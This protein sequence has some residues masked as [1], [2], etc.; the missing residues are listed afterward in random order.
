MDIA[1]VH[2]RPTWLSHLAQYTLCIGSSSGDN[3]ATSGECPCDIDSTHCVMYW[4]DYTR[5]NQELQTVWY[6][7]QLL[8]S[9]LLCT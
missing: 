9:M 6:D 7:V 8:C 3:V 1:P 5:S 2:C 4:E